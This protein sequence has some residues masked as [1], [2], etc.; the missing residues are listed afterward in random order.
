MKEWPST[1]TRFEEDSREKSNY[2]CFFLKA[3]K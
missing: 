2:N 1:Q 3:L